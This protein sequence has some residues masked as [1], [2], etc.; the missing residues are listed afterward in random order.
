[1]KRFR[2]NPDRLPQLTPAQAGR[3]DEMR[4]DDI[5]YSHIPPLDEE[6]FVRLTVA[7]T[8][9]RSRVKGKPKRCK[10]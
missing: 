10:P 8:G 6:V 7:K 5:D 9:K 4:D 2:L 3:L 1:M